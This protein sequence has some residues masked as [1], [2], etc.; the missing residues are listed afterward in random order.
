MSMFHIGKCNGQLLANTY[1][2]YSAGSKA[3]AAGMEQILCNSVFWKEKDTKI[4]TRCPTF[5]NEGY[6]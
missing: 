5:P 3:A 2:E 4:C 1:L 6:V